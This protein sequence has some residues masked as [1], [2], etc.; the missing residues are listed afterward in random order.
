MSQ[1]I[2]IFGCHDHHVGQAPEVGDIEMAVV[3][4]AV[5][6]YQSTSIQAKDDRQIRKAYIMDNLIKSPLKEGRINGDHR[7]KTLCSESC[8][9]GDGML[10]GNT[11]IQKSV[12]EGFSEVVKTG[13]LRHGSGYC[14]EIAFSLSQVDHGV[15]E[16]PRIGWG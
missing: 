15:P 2:F 1:F 12:R 5:R 14:E 10:F 6:T 3:C 13:T 4:W 11:H 9:K 8:G 16:D 7:S